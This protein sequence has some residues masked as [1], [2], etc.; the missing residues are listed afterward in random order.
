MVD[1]I[2]GCVG[3]RQAQAWLERRRRINL[4]RLH[5][6]RLRQ[7]RNERLLKELNALFLSQLETTNRLSLFERLFIPVDPVVDFDLKECFSIN[8]VSEGVKICSINRTFRT[9]LAET[10]PAT[11]SLPAGEC[12]MRF[13][14]ESATTRQIF[15][16]VEPALRF[17]S[18]SEAAA[19][20]GG[21]LSLQPN[22]GYGMLN[23]LG[24][25]TLFVFPEGVI[26]CSC[27]QGFNTWGVGA[28]LVEG[29]PSNWYAGFMVVSY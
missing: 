26:Y 27:I 13:T 10:D 16:A 22:G 18:F 4:R 8:P 14:P 23:N 29:P 12:R 7:Q 3:E 24:N 21:M 9:L 25:H 11:V 2:P 20:M 15:D 28:H 17:K 6:E 5:R 19:R 1:A